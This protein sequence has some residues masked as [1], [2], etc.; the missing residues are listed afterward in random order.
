[1]A[2]H[3]EPEDI[4]VEVERE[5]TEREQPPARVRPHP[6]TCPVCNSHY[7]EDELRDLLRVCR[8]CGHH[9]PVG[10]EERVEQL[11]DPGSFRPLPKDCAPPIRSPSPICAPTPSA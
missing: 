5:E 3:E 6:N 10:A 11:A 8:V 4:Q 9:F 2:S 7:R 1:M